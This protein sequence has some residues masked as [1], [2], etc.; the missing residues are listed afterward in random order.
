MP[1]TNIEHITIP[2]DDYYRLRA[3]NQNHAICS[4]EGDV[5]VLWYTKTSY[6]QEFGSSYKTIIVSIR[7]RLYSKIQK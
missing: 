2:Y 5:C 7:V 6:H 3:L 4:V 1:I